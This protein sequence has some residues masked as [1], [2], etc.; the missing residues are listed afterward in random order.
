MPLESCFVFGSLVFLDDLFILVMREENVKS[1]WWH[2]IFNLVSAS[3][4]VSGW[5]FSMKLLIPGH[6]LNIFPG[7]FPLVC[8]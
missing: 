7:K 3:F 4:I 8:D 2:L 6:F 1:S 5:R